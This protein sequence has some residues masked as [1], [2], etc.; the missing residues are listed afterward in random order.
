MKYLLG[1]TQAAFIHSVP[2]GATIW[3]RLKETMVVILTTPNGWDFTEQVTLRRAAITSGLVRADKAH[4]L[5]EFIS[6]G[7]ASVHYALAYSQ[8]MAWLGSNSIF[9]VIDAGGSTVD[10]TL[11]ECKATEPYVMLEEVCPSECI[12]VCTSMPTF[13]FTF[14]RVV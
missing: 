12:Q 13:P 2:N 3:N 10:S 4:E 9:G 11:Y 7:E 1:N 5:L 14:L 8:I 6:E